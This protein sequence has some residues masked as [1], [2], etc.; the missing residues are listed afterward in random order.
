MPT[1]EEHKVIMNNLAGLVQQEESC[2]LQIYTDPE[3]RKV[4]DEPLRIARKKTGEEFIVLF[5]GAF[6]SGKSS[7]INTLI[8]ER[9]LPTGFLPE[10]AV[11]GELHYGTRKKIILYPKKGQ[12]DGGDE[13]FEINPTPEEIAK[14]V[15][16]S[17][18]DAVNS[19]GQTAEGEVSEK[20]IDAKFEKMIV[21]WPLD[22]L[23]D[24]VVFVD[25]PGINDPNAND[26]IVKGYLPNA[27]AI[28][29]VMDSQHAYQGT[30]VAQL[31][32]I[33]TLGKQNIVTGYT[34]Y[35]IISN[36]ETPAQ[37]QK[38]R[39]R[40]IQYMLGNRHTELGKES[41]HFMDSLGGLK[42]RQSNDNTGWIRSGFQG[43]ESYLAQY[44]VNGKG[45][46]Q[47]KNMIATIILQAQAMIEDAEQLNSASKRDL[48]D[49]MRSIE[50]GNRQLQDIR[51]KSYQ[52]GKMFRSQLESYLPRAEQMISTF[53]NQSLPQLVDLSGFT[54]EAKLPTGISRLNPFNAPEKA[55]A[56]QEECKEE[57]IRRV[58]VTYKK[59]LSENLNDFLRNSVQ[60]STRTIEFD[61]KQIARD[62]NNVTVTISGYKSSSDGTASNIALGLGYALLTGDIVTGSLSAAYGK[63]TLLRAIGFQVGAGLA[64]GTLM[65]AGVAISLP[66]FVG[67]IIIADL[68]AIFTSDN[69]EKV[70]ALR[71]KA[72]EDF[73]KSFTS[74]ESKS[75]CDEII[76]GT[77]DN[78]RKFI[79]EACAAMEDALSKDLENT[80]KQVKKIIDESHMN[81]REKA[82]QIEKRNQIIAALAEIQTKAINLG[83]SYGLTAE[84]LTVKIGESA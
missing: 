29:Y 50:E 62:L 17:A 13:P 14:Y 60:E 43:F 3:Q 74:P 84:E 40:L 4:K 26:Y 46:A 61:L 5:I 36:Q 24:G 76:K 11:I 25:S 31:K 39:N 59:W 8:G 77:M 16:L 54:P 48:S 35:D 33:N 79:D 81:Q 58:E 1:I 51:D 70:D 53:V 9:L 75:Q 45:K 10:T 44:L 64:M 27:D 30:D 56:I 21:Y 15:S 66:V 6:S 18:D 67:G 19:M 69:E 32:E 71:H 38:T 65:A 78:V 49:I 47:A 55:Q 42:A 41:I 73:R 37:L 57:I 83:R 63:G 82:A 7:M 23:K 52:T 34:F 22:I 2:L 72:V 12:W 20:K 80:E 28:V 68:I